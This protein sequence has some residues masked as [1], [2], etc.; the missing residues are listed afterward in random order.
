MTNG[1]DIKKSQKQDAF[2]KNG[3]FA[4]TKNMGGFLEVE[5]QQNVRRSFKRRKPMALEFF[6]YPIVNP[7]E[8][9]QRNSGLGWPKQ[10]NSRW[11]LAP[12]FQLLD[13]C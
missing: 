12:V 2:S 13:V 4:L 1:I 6:F 7:Y 11:A 9:P 5:K 3:L 10:T 8:K